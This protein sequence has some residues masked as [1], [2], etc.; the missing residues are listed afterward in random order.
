M[1]LEGVPP[2]FVVVSQKGYCWSSSLLDNIR[3]IAKFNINKPWEHWLLL[4]VC[5]IMP[6]CK[7]R[8]LY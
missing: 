5:R 1:V 3:D 4:M 7:F 6:N 2:L 8:N